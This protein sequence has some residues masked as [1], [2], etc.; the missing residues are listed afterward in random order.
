MGQ[1]GNINE[2]LETESDGVNDSY[3]GVTLRGGEWNGS[4]FPLRSSSRSPYVG[5]SNPV[6][7]F[8]VASV[9]EPSSVA[10]SLLGVGVLM[11]R[12]RRRRA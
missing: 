8:R 10:A 6:G 12:R 5:K 1:S 3:S 7:G 11:A 9:P 2:W 4:G